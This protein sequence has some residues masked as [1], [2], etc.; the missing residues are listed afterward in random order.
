[1]SRTTRSSLLGLL[2][3]ILTSCVID[4][5]ILLWWNTTGMRRGLHEP[6]WLRSQIDFVALVA[7]V[8][9]G[10]LVAGVVSCWYFRQMPPPSSPPPSHPRS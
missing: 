8:V 4:R 9:L 5:A 10:V 3:F 7:G 1:M 6:G 2:T